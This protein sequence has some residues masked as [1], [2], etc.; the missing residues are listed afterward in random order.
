MD[1][2]G[3]QEDVDPWPL[4]V[5]HRLPSPV[6]VGLPAAGQA[7]NARPF[8]RL[9]DFADRLEVAG[10]GDREA[11]LDHVDPQ[12]GEG[13]GNLHLL[14]QIHACPGRLLAVA[15]RGIENHNAS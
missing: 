6:D 3:G 1:R 7:A 4:G 5:L 2:A 9:G 13:L 8:H 10:R 11:G 14:A 15:E 12:V